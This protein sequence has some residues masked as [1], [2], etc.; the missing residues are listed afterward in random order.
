MFHQSINVG[1]PLLGYDSYSFGWTGPG[2]A[3]QVYSDYSDDTAPIQAYKVTTAQQ[4]ADFK[5]YLDSQLG[6]KEQYGIDDYCR[7]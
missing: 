6:K 7:S 3:G 2:L 5:K 1:D 4:D